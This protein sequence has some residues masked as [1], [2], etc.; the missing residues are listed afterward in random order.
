[1][2]NPWAS[3][4]YTGEW[5]DT[6]PQWTDELKAQVDLKPGNDGI[7]YVTMS[8]AREAFT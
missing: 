2:R 3:D 8:V 4:I 5:N 6:D 1:M 7:F